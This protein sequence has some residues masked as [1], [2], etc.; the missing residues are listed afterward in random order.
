MNFGAFDTK[1]QEISWKNRFGVYIFVKRFTMIPVSNHVYIKEKDM[2]AEL[3]W[4]LSTVVFALFVIVT[5]SLI[6]VTH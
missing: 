4:S 2:S 3:R 1:V 6:A 5:Y